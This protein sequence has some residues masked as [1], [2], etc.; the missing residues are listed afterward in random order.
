MKLKRILALA[1]LVCV[2]VSLSTASAGSPWI[3]VNGQN[4]KARLYKGWYD[5][6]DP[7]V[8]LLMKWSK[9]WTPMAVEP[10]GAWV[11]NHLTWYSNEYN[12]DTWY[13]WYAMTNFEEGNYR[14]EEFVKIMSVGNDTEAWA[15]YKAAGAVTAGWGEYPSGVPKIIILTDNITVYE[16]T[17]NNVIMKFNYVKGVPQ[18]LGRPSF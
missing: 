8:W 6:N 12:E 1:L 5:N 4:M 10:V 2:V 9:D 14:I 17:T 11:T 7:D 18:G 15:E 3:D 13:G 16:G